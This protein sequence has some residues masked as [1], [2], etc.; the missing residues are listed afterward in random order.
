MNYNEAKEQLQNY[1]GSQS[2]YVCGADSTSIAK[3]LAAK[4]WCSYHA[5]NI[6][7]AVYND[8]STNNASGFS[9]L[10]AGY[11]NSAYDGTSSSSHYWSASYYNNGDALS[12]SL[13]WNDAHTTLAYWVPNS[14]CSVRCLRD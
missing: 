8:V 10:P 14:G 11:Y 2:Q 9:A 5:S 1:L 7:C 4:S 3:A 6:D 12:F 13:S